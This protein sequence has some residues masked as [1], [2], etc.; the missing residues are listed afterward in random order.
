M[1]RHFIALIVS[2]ATSH[3][4][5]SGSSALAAPAPQQN[6]A[7]TS[8]FNLSYLDKLDREKIDLSIP[9]TQLEEA[10][11]LSEK[12]MGLAQEEKAADAIFCYEKAL[13]LARNSVDE[14]ILDVDMG[15]VYSQQGNFK[16]G[17]YYYKR[18]TELAP[19]LQEA[20]Y[21][22]GVC[23]GE[24]K[25][26]HEA[27]RCFLKALAIDPQDVHSLGNL[28]EI[29]RLLGDLPKSR[30]Y[31]EKGLKLAQEESDRSLIHCSLSELQK[32]ETAAANQAER[33]AEDRSQFSAGL[34]RIQD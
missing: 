3:G 1:T 20:W 10:A 13:D 27:K 26:F 4:V 9:Q 34:D 30:Q 17:R 5:S 33:Q 14:P 23:N 25:R 21:G 24:L 8:L 22:L 12:A 32:A 2:I 29:Y 6:S 31:L 18:A 15:A 11:R 19:G 16:K 7:V 28:G